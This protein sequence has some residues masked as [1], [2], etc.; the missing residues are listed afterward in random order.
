MITPLTDICY[1]TLSQALG[2]FL[3]GAPA[4]PAGTGKTETTK[5]LPMLWQSC[6]WSVC[7]LAGQNRDPEGVPLTA[8]GCLAF[9]C[10]V[11]LERCTS[12]HGFLLTAWGLMCTCA[13]ETGHSACITAALLSPAA[14]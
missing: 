7:L 6:A 8:V 11:L 5:V 10:F 4:G 13:H 9:S 1:V 2:M 12:V 14:S 3:G